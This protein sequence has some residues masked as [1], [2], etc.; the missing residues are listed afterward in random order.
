MFKQY[1]TNGDGTISLDEF[2]QML[3]QAHSVCV[4]V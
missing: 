3:V 4:C 2:E 1:D